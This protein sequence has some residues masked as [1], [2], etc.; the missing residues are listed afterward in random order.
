MEVSPKDHSQYDGAKEEKGPDETRVYQLRA[1]L[2]FHVSEPVSDRP[3]KHHTPDH[4]GVIDN[5]DSGN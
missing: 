2:T 4:A 1:L 3:D 5:I